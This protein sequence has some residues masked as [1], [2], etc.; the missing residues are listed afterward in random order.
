MKRSTKMLLMNQGKEKAAI[1]GLSMMIGGLKTAIRI[2][3]GWRTASATALAVSTT[4]MDGT[5][6]CPQ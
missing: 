4:T 1:S 6:Q 2:L 5:P 3:T